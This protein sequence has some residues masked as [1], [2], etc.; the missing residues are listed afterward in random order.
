MD[1]QPQIHLEPGTVYLTLGSPQQVQVLLDKPLYP[2]F[3]FEPTS[4]TFTT[5]VE[6]ILEEE[7]LLIV[8]P[9]EVSL[10]KK[11]KGYF[12]QVLY[13][14]PCT[15]C[16]VCLAGVDGEVT[17]ET[18]KSVKKVE[19]GPYVILDLQSQPKFPLVTPISI[20][21]KEEAVSLIDALLTV[22]G[23]QRWANLSWETYYRLLRP[24]GYMYSPLL[25]H[26]NAYCL[27]I[28]LN[29]FLD[30]VEY[31]R[32][33][34]PLAVLGS[35]AQWVYFLTKYWAEPG[36]EGF[37]RRKVRNEWYWTLKLSTQARTHWLKMT[38]VK[39]D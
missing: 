17:D 1:T 11:G 7:Q 16:F 34:N 15:F 19:G 27:D 37:F 5:E 6:C 12:P 29:W 2:R 28:Y 20:G 24:P 25:S 31:E 38:G 36:A 21:E 13:P 4:S 18:K 23:V 8:I 10:S 3:L 22:E 30:R 35:F 33:S 26:S 14:S 39:H 32:S 9:P